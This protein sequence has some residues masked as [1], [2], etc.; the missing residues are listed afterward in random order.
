MF[1]SFQTV[2]NDSGGVRGLWRG[3]LPSVFRTG[4]GAALY[5]SSLNSLR[6]YVAHWQT[7]PVADGAKTAGEAVGYQSSALPRLTNTGNLATGAVARASVGFIMMPATVLKVRYESDLYSYRSIGSAATTIWQIEGLRGFFSG[8]GATALRD[9]PYAGVYVL[10][11]EQCKQKLGH[12]YQ[13]SRSNEAA[14]TASTASI[15][16]SMSI[17]LAASAI[18][19]G[20]ATTITNPFDVLKT[21]LQLM[22]GRYSNIL[23]AARHMYRADGMKSLFDGLGLR[24]GRKAVSAALTWTIYEEMIKHAQ[25]VLHS[26]V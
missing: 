9:A 11:Y 21:R 23:Q 6:S 7:P 10:F 19:A 8:Y 18:A 24:M 5:F 26:P 16:P 20:V 22:P 25:S 13:A 3:T 4:V 2:L 12:A 17:N 14:H 1:S 15:L